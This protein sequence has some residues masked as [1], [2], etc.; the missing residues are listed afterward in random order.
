MP[1]SIKGQHNHAS[2]GTFYYEATYD[3]HRPGST[4]FIEWSGVATGAARVLTLSGGSIELIAGGPGAA[5]LI[6]H[7]QIRKEIDAL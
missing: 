4:W 5:E 1:H 3:V 7:K 6:L 2:L